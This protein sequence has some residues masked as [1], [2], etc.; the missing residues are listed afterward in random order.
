MGSLSSAVFRQVE[1]LDA[2]CMF[3]AKLIEMFDRSVNNPLS[4]EAAAPHCISEDVSAGT[5][6]AELEAL[7]SN[8]ELR[9]EPVSIRSLFD[10]SLSSLPAS[11]VLSIST[12]RSIFNADPSK[13]SAATVRAI[14]TEA[15]AQA[16]CRFRPRLPAETGG[17]SQGPPVLVSRV[18]HLGR[19][20]DGNDKAAGVFVLARKVHAVHGEQRAGNFGGLLNRAV[21]P[22]IEFWSPWQFRLEGAPGADTLPAMQTLV[23]PDCYGNRDLPF[24]ERIK[25]AESLRRLVLKTFPSYFNRVLAHFPAIKELSLP[26]MS[27]PDLRSVYDAL[28][29]CGWL[30]HLHLHSTHDRFDHLIE[31]VARKGSD[32]RV[33]DF[34]RGISLDAYPTSSATRP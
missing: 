20:R 17:G 29:S 6:N 23:W 33:L 19:R 16:P 3:W 9:G 12:V 34:D 27:G 24:L 10:R 5:Q 4:L 32:L 31:Y 2:P 25:S 30:T 13:I 1:A 14:L 11:Y 22:S 26:D 8:L 18:P 15:A 21:G 28:I 7:V